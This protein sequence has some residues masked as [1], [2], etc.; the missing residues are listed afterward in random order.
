MAHPPPEAVMNLNIGILGHVD[1]GKTSLA[2]ALSEVAGTAAFDKNPQSQERGITIDLGFS[3][4]IVDMPAHLHAQTEKENLQFTF[5]DCPGHASLIRTIIGGSQIIHM[6]ILVIDVTKG[7]QTQTAECLVIG[8]IMCKSMIVVL[9]KT[10]LLPSEKRDAL[11]EKMKKKMSLTL[12]NTVFKAAPIIAVAANPVNAGTDQESSSEGLASL[13]NMLKEMAYIPRKQLDMPFV[14]AV[15]H[16]FSIRGQGTIL[17]GTVLQGKVSLKDEIQVPAI[18][19]TAKVKSMQMFRRPVT[20]AE[21]GDRLGLCVP[22][23]DPKQLERGLVCHPNYIP[24]MWAAILR[25]RRIKYFQGSV[26]TKDKFHISIGHETVM[27]TITIFNS[28][29]ISLNSSHSIDLSSDFQS[30]DELLQGEDSFMLLQFERPLLAPPNSLAIGSRLEMDIN[31]HACR[32]AFSGT[33]VHQ[34]ASKDYEKDFL[35]HLKIFKIKERKGTVERIVNENTVIVKSLI[36]KETN[37]QVFVGLKVELSNGETGVIENTFGKSGKLNVYVQDGLKPETIAQYKK[38]ET[39]KVAGT[40]NPVEVV[41]KF[42]RYIFDVEVREDEEQQTKLQETLDLLVAAGY[43]RARIKGLS[44]FDKVV[45]GLTWCIEMCNFDIDVDLLFQENL[46]IGQKIS[47]TEKIV[48]VL[49]HMKCPHRIEPHQIQGLDFIHI[50]PVI[51]WLV[52]RSM[53]TRAERAE[54][55]R[56]HAVD[57]YKRFYGAQSDS[58]H[59]L[60]VASNVRQ[61]QETFRPQRRFRR[62]LPAQPDEDLTTRVHS[63]LLEYG[64][65]SSSPFRL[66]KREDAADPQ[67]ELS[68]Q[69]QEQEKAEELRVKALMKNMASAEDQESRLSAGLV[70]S[71]VNLQAEEI[72]QAARHYEKLQA[73]FEAA[74]QTASARALQALTRQQEMLKEK[75]SKL[76]AEAEELR[77]S[78]HKAENQIETAK[79]QQSE[80]NEQLQQLNI[81]GNKSTVQTL[82][83]LVET[84]DSLK[85]QEARF[86]EQCRSELARLQALALEAAEGR[87][88]TEGVDVAE[89][90]ST[91]ASE[92]EALVAVRLRLA[93]ATRAAASLQRQLDDVPGRAELAQYQRRFLELYSQVAAK[94]KE[95]KQFYTLYNTLSD[96]KLYMEKELTLLDSIL[97]NYHEALSSPSMREQFIKQFEGIVENVK[98]NKMKIEQRRNEERMRRDKLNKQQVA[99]LELERSYVAAVRQL[100]VECRKNAVLLAQLRASETTHK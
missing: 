66:G 76:H 27:A 22:Q 57:Q 41:L 18:G 87:T 82:Q 5:V 84:Y 12:L 51:Q 37:A 55:M 16:C 47:L 53:E 96:T 33:I 60:S 8:E 11:I 15:D 61:V 25:V 31:G 62:Q 71:I 70:G 42:K 32:L 69:L 45:G 14:F 43:F 46:T 3:S 88:G 28:L 77:S 23:L 100:T 72:A 64:P 21:E 50:F 54:R 98:Q 83:T 7:M 86:R 40:V 19:F 74:P 79:K 2:K 85:E 97:E 44:P 35:P 81:S 68:S 78:L 59:T 89:L 17:T 52:K 39:K 73:T 99:L 48:A 1:S 13:L 38:G 49:P 95:T 4:I 92:K 65:L 80:L 63:T 34:V 30:K 20:C 75:E 9:N 6:M 90:G 94:H 24:F 36:K 93:R 91:L 10:D 29:E 67:S 56:A 58:T 26:K